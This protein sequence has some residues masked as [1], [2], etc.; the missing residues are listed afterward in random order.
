MSE[1]EHRISA[2]YSTLN[3]MENHANKMVMFA[4][5][6]REQLVALSNGEPIEAAAAMPNQSQPVDGL[7]IKKELRKCSIKPNYKG[8]AYLVDAIGIVLEDPSFIGHFGG[9][10]YPFIAE[11]YGSRGP[12]IERSIRH[13]IESGYKRS[14][15]REGFRDL[16]GSLDERPTNT[17][18]IAMVAERLRT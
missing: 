18:F 16:F 2:I 10:L 12:L 4:R 13:A 7:D 5:Y 1:Q 9:K 15:G 6:A 11:K 3:E 14:F 17:E 8:Y